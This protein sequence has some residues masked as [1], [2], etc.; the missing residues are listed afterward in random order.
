MVLAA[1]CGPMSG[2]ALQGTPVIREEGG[3]VRFMRASLKGKEG[4]LSP[5]SASAGT[6]S[7]GASKGYLVPIM[8]VGSPGYRFSST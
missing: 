7:C 5:S 3:D 1:M 4:P 8:V 6:A 2:L